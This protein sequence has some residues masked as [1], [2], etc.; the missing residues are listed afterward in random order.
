VRELEA[1]AP[2]PDDEEKLAE[3]RQLLRAGSTLGEAVTR[4]W[5]S[6][7][8]A[9]ARSAPCARHIGWSN[10]MPT[11]RWDGSTPRLPRSIGR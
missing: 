7:S 4:R 9:A 1:L 8:M 5:P 2:R 3:E 6:W 10:A 11:K